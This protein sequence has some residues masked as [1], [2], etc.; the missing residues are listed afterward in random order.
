MAPLIHAITTTALPAHS[1]P[2]GR[3]RRIRLRV[4]DRAQ[5]V[6]SPLP[7]DPHPAGRLQA[8]AS[9]ATL[10][11]A[12]DSR[13][14]QTAILAPVAGRP[15]PGPCRE[16]RRLDRPPPSGPPLPGLPGPPARPARRLRLRL[17]RPILPAPKEPHQV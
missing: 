4:G 13:P 1:R 9:A 16:H 10:G 5:L 3:R 7:G 15:R 14:D 11:R 6:R 2:P 12:P 17:E 8:A